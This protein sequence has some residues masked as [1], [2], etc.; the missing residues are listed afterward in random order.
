[1]KLNS[2][3]QVIWANN[4]FSRALFNIVLVLKFGT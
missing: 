4:N 1:M 3:K 2:V